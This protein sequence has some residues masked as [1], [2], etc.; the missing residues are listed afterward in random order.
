MS[1][2]AHRGASLVS[3]VEVMQ[4]LLGDGGCPWDREQSLNDLK[5]YVVEE[6]HEVCD[7]I[8]GLGPDA[9]RSVTSPGAVQAGPESEAV[10]DLREELGDL[11]LQVVF[12]SEI[13]AHFG[14]FTVDD[15]VAA[16]VDKLH[17]RHPHVFGDQKVSGTREVLA[18]W[19]KIKQAEKRDRGLLDGVPRGLPSLLAAAR[20]GEKASRVGFDW[21]DPSGPRARVDDELAELDEAIAS[22]DR[23]AMQHELGDVLFTV[24]NLARKLGLDADA[25]LGET[26]RTF[27]R[28]FNAVEAQARAAGTTV[29]ACSPE[30]LDAYWNEAKRRERDGA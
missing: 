29:D 9:A 4:R 15:V 16:I 22:G 7:A 5:R 12:Q 26:N 27:R 23:A 10:R 19:E 17:R 13:A 21:P 1:A 8:D 28:R 20:M 18:N 2:K 6:A 14:W 30:T 11:A 24:V 25:A 3:L